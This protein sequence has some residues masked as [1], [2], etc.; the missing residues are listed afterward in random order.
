MGKLV[1]WFLGTI[2]LLLAGLASIGLLAY[3]VLY[4]TLPKDNGTLKLAG[5]T[6]PV[7]VVFDVNAI[8]HIEAENLDDAMHVLGF[9]HAR[10][11]LWQMEFLRRVGQGRLSEILGDATVDTDIF[12]RTLDMAGAAKLSY[13]KL[14]P[15]TKRAL[16]AYANGVNAYQQRE[17]NLFEPT[18]GV[19]FMILGHTPEPWE[20]WNSV[21]ILKVMGFSLGKNLTAEIQRLALASRGMSPQEIND[22]LP[23]S[24]RDNPLPLPDLR[25]L[26]GFGE[27]G[28]EFEAASISGSSSSDT[29]D[30]PFVFDFPIGRSASNNWVISGTKTASGKPILAND[31]HLGLTAPSAFYLAHLS[32]AHQGT[33]HDLIG[34]TLPGIP[35]FVTGRNSRVAWGLT[36]ANLDAQDLYIEKLNPENPDE[37]LTENGWREFSSTQLEIGISGEESKLLERRVTR[38]GPVLPDAFRNLKKLLPEGHVASLRWNGLATDDTTLDT[39]MAN[40]FARNVDE[41][42]D[43]TKY[44][45]S[46]MQAVVVGDVDGNIALTTPGRI[47]LRSSANAVKGRAPVPGWLTQYQW[48]GFIKSKDIPRIVNPERGALTTAN[49]N[50]LPADYPH[51]ITYDWAEHFR[52]ARAEELVYGA[53]N[54]HDAA[55]SKTIMADSF[56]PPLFEL[57]KLAS[58]AELAG[59][60]EKG[61]I[62]SALTRWDGRMNKESPEP[63]IMLAWFRHLH[64]AIYKDD[65]GKEYELFDRGRITRVLRVLKQGTARDWCDRQGTEAKE[66][67]RQILSE[68]F[69]MAISELKTMQGEDWRQWQYGKAHLGFS[70]HRPFGK[71]KPLDRL[72]NIKVESSGGPYTLNRGQMYFG[73]DEPYFNRHAASYRAIYDF[74]DL[75]KSVFI[76]S[77]GQS[78]NPMSQH[79]RDFAKL[80]SQSRFVNMTTDKEAYLSGAKGTWIFK[81]E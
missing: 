5:L 57:V 65:F 43:A 58:R 44:A 28:K 48:T 13:E 14:Q 25:E 51:H 64:E 52:Q 75:D 63:I 23:Y 35:M 60:G 68:S 45:V 6:S 16:A 62:F 34:G 80:W 9:V 20:A 66:G 41:F 27:N 3:G 2:V 38:N 1:K 47:P 53:K 12:L 24:P 18:R 30:N 15:E 72:F 33:A 71:V 73:Q 11:R 49:A 54:S 21:L 42:L 67:C 4:G 46:P 40:M 22:V 61:D 55:L 32:F 10:D 36:T 37:Y 50:F 59:A 19:E 26:Y 8:P 39:L 17:T 56:S 79:Y 81:P 69:E 7:Q 77:S 29:L 76:Q 74:S 78:G 31:P 70:E